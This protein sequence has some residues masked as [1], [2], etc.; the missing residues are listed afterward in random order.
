[1]P[2]YLRTKPEPNAEQK[3]IAHETKAGTLSMEAAAK[4]VTQFTK[5]LSHIHDLV[6]KAREEWENFGENLI[7]LDYWSRII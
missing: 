2:D 4:Q 1:M 3:M 6:S 7:K 5:I